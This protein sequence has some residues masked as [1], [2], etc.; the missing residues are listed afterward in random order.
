MDNFARECGEKFEKN[1]WHVRIRILR[2]VNNLSQKEFAEK[3]IITEKCVWSWESGNSVPSKRNKKVI[4]AV[5]GVDEKTIF[6]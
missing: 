4:A 2:K 6:G 1:K 3:C 5:L